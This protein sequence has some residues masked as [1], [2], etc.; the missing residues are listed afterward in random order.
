MVNCWVEVS[1]TDPGLVLLG[2][3]LVIEIQEIYRDD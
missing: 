3:L 1:Q 2:G